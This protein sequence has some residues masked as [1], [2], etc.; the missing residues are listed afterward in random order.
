MIMIIGHENALNLAILKT[1]CQALNQSLKD[2]QLGDIEL[3]NSQKWPL[4]CPQ[5]SGTLRQQL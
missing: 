2:W 5:G 4:Y 3:L 1:A